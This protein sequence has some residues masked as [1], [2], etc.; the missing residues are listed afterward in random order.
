MCFNNSLAWAPQ[1]PVDA[2]SSLQGRGIERFTGF[3]GVLLR[4]A[5]GGVEA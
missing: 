1:L 3:L 5:G 4:V 2:C